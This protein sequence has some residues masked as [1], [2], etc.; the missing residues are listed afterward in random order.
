MKILHYTPRL[1]AG[2]LLADHI[3]AL[4]RATEDKAS[5]SVA[6]S[7]KAAIDAIRAERPDILHVHGSWRWLT[8]SVVR[9]AERAGCATILS[10]HHQLDPYPTR[11]E[12]RARKAMQRLL[13]ERSLTRRYDALLV[14]TERESQQL[15]DH[16]WHDR[17]GIVP[18]SV[19][20]ATCTEDE[21]GDRAMAF[22]QKVCDTRYELLMTDDEHTCLQTLLHVG[23]LHDPSRRQV[24]HEHILLLRQLKPMQWRRMMLMA[25]DEDI[26]QTID[27]AIGVMQID[28]PDIDATAINRFDSLH[29]KTKGALPRKLLTGNPI[30]KGKIKDILAEQDAE[31]KL[32]VT[33]LINTQ[34]LLAEQRLSLRHVADL[35]ES[36]RYTDF[37]E[38]Q[39]KATIK[40]LGMTKFARR[41]TQVVATLLNLSEGYHPIEPLDD[42][43][44][45]RYI[46]QIT[47][48]K[49]KP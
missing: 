38:D 37:D 26:R 43:T 44:T 33:D 17:I 1:V 40:Q 30:R 9:A 7:Q 13:Y 25:D 4:V 14:S 36:L 34:H 48:R 32:V 8:R 12:K 3:D 23:A 49:S 2:D 19:L 46:A 16:Q 35:F 21:M 5:V 42:T 18:S 6:S 41:M 27:K 15:I 28:A 47:H 29:P 24:S 22:Y 11:H 10:P 45:H 39:F 31:V 20:D